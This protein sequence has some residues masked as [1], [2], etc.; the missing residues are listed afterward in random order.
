M[1]D[2]ELKIFLESGV[3]IVVGTCDGD[4]VP[5][6]VRGYAARV[7][8]QDKAIQ[9]FLGRAAA[10]RTLANL[11]VNRRI[12]VTFCSPDNYRTVQIKGW[13]RNVEDARPEDQAVIDRFQDAFVAIVAKYGLSH[14]IRNIWGPDPVRLSFDPESVFD[15][16]PGPGAGRR[17]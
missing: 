11:R 7:S 8:E 13:F 16:T 9:L 6:I 3:A 10:E 1:I 5:E 14:V 4:L 2:D 17:L 15:Q 12:A